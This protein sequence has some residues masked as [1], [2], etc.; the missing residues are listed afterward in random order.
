MKVYM[1]LASSAKKPEKTTGF[2]QFHFDEN[3]WTSKPIWA[4]MATKSFYTDCQNCQIY[5]GKDPGT[6]NESTTFIYEALDLYMYIHHNCISSYIYSTRFLTA[7]NYSSN[8]YTYKL[9]AW[10]VGRTPV[11]SVTKVGGCHQTGESPCEERS[12]QWK[13]YCPARSSHT[14]PAPHPTGGSTARNRFMQ[15]THHFIFM[16]VKVQ[17]TYS[18]Y[19]YHQR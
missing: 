17:G 1:P 13:G 2:L 7:I 18:V 4:K 3:H 9:G 12:D 14:A 10:C 19:P 5:N 15:S 16:Q 8:R 6:R 11:L